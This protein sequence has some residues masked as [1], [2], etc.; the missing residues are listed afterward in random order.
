MKKLLLIAMVLFTFSLRAEVKLNHLPPL[1]LKPNSAT[2]ITLSFS[3]STETMDEVTLFFRE[4]G[5]LIFNENTKNEITANSVKFTLPA[6]AQTSGG[7]EY[8]FSILYGENHQ[9]L[10]DSQ[11]QTNPY[12]VYNAVIDSHT[13][14]FILLNSSTTV[15]LNEDL[16]FAVSVYELEHNIDA[17]TIRVHLN[18]EDIT[19]TASINLPIILVRLEQPKQGQ[20][21]FNVSAK[22]NSGRTLQS[23]FWKMT[24]IGREVKTATLPLNMRGNAIFTSNVRSISE[25]DSSAYSGSVKNN[26]NL[27]LNVMGRQ[28]WFGFRTRFFLSSNETKKKQAINRYSIGL[29]VPSLEL[30]LID[31][32]PNYGTFLLNNRNVR[33]I[34]GKVYLGNLSLSSTYGHI[35]R[36]I[37]GKTITDT[38]GTEHYTGGVFKRNTLAANLQLGGLE[39][40]SLSVG[41]AKNKDQMSSLEEKYFLRV[42]SD[43]TLT[44]LANPQDN[45]VL[46][47]G[48]RM[49]LLNQKVVLGAEAA[50]SMYNSNIIDGALSQ[51]ELEEYLE[52]EELPFNPEDF[53]NIIIINKNIEP[54]I[55]SKANL[56]YQFYFRWFLAN[57]FLNATYSQV[58]ASFR[59][60]SSSYL[61]NDASMLSVS[62]YLT[63]FNNRFSLS[64]GLN[65]TVDNLS[66]QKSTTTKNTNWYAQTMF[67]PTDLPYFRFGYFT[68]SIADDQTVKQINQDMNNFNFG[69]GYEINQLPMTTAGVDIAY[70]LSQDKDN[71]INKNFDFNRNNFQLTIQNTLDAIPLTTRFFFSTNSETDDVS[72][73]KRTYGTFNVHN[74]YALL[75]RRLIPYFDIRFNTFGGDQTAQSLANYEL[76]A[77]YSPLVST[78]IRTRVDIANYKNNDLIGRDYTLTAW[79]LYVSQRF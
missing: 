24:V 15:G 40:L 45:I 41:F 42:E 43:S 33:G 73:V 11:P 21:V 12:R 51:E 8:Y 56:A 71:S 38:L 47:S 58:G 20:F 67:R 27:R 18:G 9:T 6:L 16:I 77:E 29:S 55:P 52:G 54:I 68:N 59:S 32:T 10:P 25:S 60:L 17:E 48:A 79:Y 3:G 50:V 2:E 76:G 26:A 13:T 34:S 62:D 5:E 22:D 28:A 1:Q 75:N 23:P 66:K 4:T 46:G 53:K 44:A 61:Q 49:G 14:K 7:Y 37:D 36:S 64:A 70:S 35:A 69:V 63:L 57:N 78:K 19:A 65:M 31:S 74:E 72:S 39:G 30:D